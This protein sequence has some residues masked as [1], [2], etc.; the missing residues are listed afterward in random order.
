[1]KKIVFIFLLFFTSILSTAQKNYNSLWDTVER[2]EVD[3]LP[4]SALK[5]VDQI[6]IDAL[7][8][9]NDAQLVKCLIFKSK[10]SLYLEENSQLKI[11]NDFKSQISKASFPSKSILESMLANLYWQYFTRNRYKIYRRTK[12]K[13]KVDLIDFRTWGINTLFSEIHKHYKASLENKSSLQKIDIN[14]YHEIL[15]IVNESKEYRPTL[16]DFLAHNTLSFYKTTESN[17]TKPAYQFKI[18]NPKLLS[19]SKTFS[20]LNITTKDSLSL[21]YNALKIYQNLISFHQKR[22]DNDAL[23]SVDIERLNFVKKHAVLKDK[24]ELLIKTLEYSEN[25]FANHELSGLYAYEK[26]YVLKLSKKI[27]DSKNNQILQICNRIIKKFPK[28]LAANKCL[29]LKTIIENKSLKIVAEKHIPIQ[30]NSRLLITYKN[31]DHLTFNIYKASSEQRIQFYRMHTNKEKIAFIDKLTKVT[32]WSSKLRNENDYLEHSTEVIVP[33][34]DSGSYLIVASEKQQLDLDAIYGTSFIQITNLAL[35]S[36]GSNSFQV[37][38]RNNGKPIENAVVYVRHKRLKTDKNGFIYPHVNSTQRNV[39][40]NVIYKKDK[41]VFE[42]YYL[43]ENDNYDDDEDEDE[44]IILTPFIFTDRAIYRP[45]QK[46]FFKVIVIKKTK[47]KSSLFTKEYIDV[48]LEDTNGKEIKRHSLQL[49]EFG[50]ISGEFII[51]NN[52]LTGEYSIYAEENDEKDSKFYDYKDYDFNSYANEKTILVEEYKRSKF[53]TSFNPITKAYNVYDSISLTG[54]ATSFS[55]ANISNAKAVYKVTRKAVLPR[56]TDWGSSRNYSEAQEI[57]QGEITTNNKGEFI[58]NFKAIPDESID[59]KDTPIF[60]YVITVD[61]T[62]IN[63]ETR[64]TSATVKVGYHSLVAKIQISDEIDRTKASQSIRITTNNLNDQ[65]IPTKGILKIYKLKSPK[66]PLRKRIWNAPD[67][68]EISKKRFKEL[69]PHESYTKDE[70]YKKNWEKGI[71]VLE[72]NFDT[73]DNKEIQLSEIKEWLTGNYI[74]ILEAK[75]KTGQLITDQQIFLLFDTEEK[76]VSDNQLFTFSTDKPYYKPKE[77]VILKIGSASKDMTVFVEIEKN[78]A[79]VKTYLIHL[80]NE[81]K[82][83]K[84][85]VK[86]S[87]LGGFAVRYHFVNYNYFESNIRIVNVLE[88][89]KSLAIETQV[90]KDKLQPGQNETWSFAIKNDKKNK[91]TAEVLASMYDASLD[92]FKENFWQFNPIISSNYYS[93]RKSSAYKSFLTTSFRVRNTRYLSFY[94]IASRR[95]TSFNWFGF[96][97]NNNTWRRNNYLKELKTKIDAE[98]KNYDKIITGNVSDENGPLPGTSILIKGTTFGT[99]ADFEGN[100]SIKVKKGDVLIYSYIGYLPEE[101]TVLNSKVI[102][103]LMEEDSNQLNEVVVTGYT[104]TTRKK[105]ATSS[106]IGVCLVNCRI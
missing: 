72:T 105:S 14:K 7:K 69:F 16:Y 95:F 40:I 92:Q 78:H 93:Y 23:V 57:S 47:K 55:G 102:D 71:M 62:D 84:I 85:P 48:Y 65:F 9:K 106:T 20:Q 39:D 82:E 12:T 88:E 59:K 66:N 19:D 5:I 77:N 24:E 68:Q 36:G 1:M 21:Q 35:I 8:E 56:W 18:D 50:S 67:Y 90:F 101:S 73:K 63:G 94:N 34:L 45:G 86:K 27:I 30:K 37:V 41:A 6:Y 4:K 2:L 33:K 80:N 81:I 96:D 61:V 31:I 3:N 60:N 74:A 51:P 87:D 70:N 98:R 15:T 49:N 97:F 26:A 38:N 44:E 42:N 28:S 76:K 100:Y 17:I 54:L 99:D 32:S 53:E 79:V 89:Q 46:A 11:I 29:Q 43:Y 13:V 64:S 75:D 104:T 91:V 22:K 58:I 25:R 103:I 52:G 83:I 10:F